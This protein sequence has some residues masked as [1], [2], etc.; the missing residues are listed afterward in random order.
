MNCILCGVGGQGTV[1]ASKLIAQS[2]MK[3]GFFARTAETMG[4]AQRGGSVVSQVRT[5]EQVPSPLI[6][7]HEADVLIGFEPAEAVRALRYLKENGTV[8]VSTRGI[9]P[10]T[11]SL[12]GNSYQEKEMLDYLGRKVPH[13]ILVDSEKICAQ[14]GNA[15]VLNVALLGAAAQAGILDASREEMEQAIC[16]KV[17]ARFIDVNLKALRLGAEA[18]KGK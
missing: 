1:L 11:A 12:T 5:G 9:Q 18:A 17:N 8:I 13:M 16:E 10:V 4:M 3:K 2:A 15:K 14:C 7:E 6:P